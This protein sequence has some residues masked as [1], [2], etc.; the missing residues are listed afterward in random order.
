MGIVDTEL[1]KHLIEGDLDKVLRGTDIDPQEFQAEVQQLLDIVIN[2]LYT[3]KEIFIRELVSNAA[4][5][6]EKPPAAK[7][8][9]SRWIPPD[10][11]KP[12]VNVCYKRVPRQFVPRRTK[13][14]PKQ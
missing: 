12:R 11:P 1:H 5:A 4:D 6:L 9:P 10:D 13:K 8:L 7:A 3:D 14:Y 2:S